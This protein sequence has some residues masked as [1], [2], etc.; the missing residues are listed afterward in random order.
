MFFRKVS[1]ETHDD[2]WVYTFVYEDYKDENEDDSHLMKYR[3]FGMN[4]RYN[5]N[6]NYHQTI[7]RNFEDATVSREPYIE[8][9]IPPFLML[10]E[11][12]E[13]EKKDMQLIETILD[14]SNSVEDLLSINSDNYI[15]EV[16]DKEMFFKLMRTALEGEPQKEGGDWD[17]PIYAF[18][19]EPVYL[20]DYKFQI[21]F[22]Q[23]TGGVD[24][25]YIDVLYQTGDNYNDYVKLSDLVENNS[26]TAEQRQA[27]AKI[28]E[29]VNG[30]K[31]SDTFI[32]ESESYKAD[33]IGDVD[34]SRLYNFLNNIHDNKFDLYS[35][36][37]H[38]EI[39]EKD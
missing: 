23:E 39:V 38:V 35:K 12:S 33:K 31:E 37:P 7:T 26:A 1:R 6:E 3:F 25:I 11:G 36:G 15:F 27:F 5:Y 4:L 30:I 8:I 13:A 17:K 24:E 14:S 20:S 2:G 16:I 22:L 34:F 29:I 10:G 18:F 28:T 19:S 9:I 32:F 21:A